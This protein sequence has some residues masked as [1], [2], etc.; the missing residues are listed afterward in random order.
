MFCCFLARP[1]LCYDSFISNLPFRLFLPCFLPAILLH[2]SVINCLHL[3]SSSHLH[4]FVTNWSSC[5]LCHSSFSLNIFKQFMLSH[6]LLDYL[7]FSLWSAF[8]SLCKFTLCAFSSLK[9]SYQDYLYVG[10]F[11]SHHDRCS[12]NP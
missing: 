3:F 1:F 8:K 5:F 9:Q 7:S 6:N 4:M 11:S 10:P 12:V 2:G